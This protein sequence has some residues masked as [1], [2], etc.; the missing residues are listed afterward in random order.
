MNIH[1]FKQ[2]K[3]A[4]QK[5]TLVTCYD[6][7]L[8]RILDQ[9]AINGIL[10]GDSAAMVIHGHPHTVTAS[11]DMM[12]MHTAAVARGLTKKLL[13]AD[14]PFLSY[15][16]SLA[17]TMD[18]VE[19]LVQAGAHAI[20]LEGAAGN[21]DCIRHIVESGVPVM[22]HIGLTP[23]HVHQLGGYR[24]QGTDASTQAFLRKEAD[25]LLEAGCF[26]I[27]L[28]CMP[29]DLANEITQ[30]LPIPTIG[31]GAGSHT[32]GQILVLYDLLG[33]TD[34]KPTFAK[35]YLQGA[36]LVQSAIDQY[37][38]EVSQPECPV[39]IMARIDDENPA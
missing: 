2:R 13:I 11:M 37:I 4:Q 36:E 28:E 10:V 15:R 12:V 18:C 14:L 30:R 24:I 35:Q 23:Q 7:T 27:V 16:K 3:D 26:A 19:R 22:G 38:A 8:A 20:K 17:Q 9:T 33:L 5:I 31:I 34:F 6:F 32:D 21:A 25:M 39:S 29:A 1:G